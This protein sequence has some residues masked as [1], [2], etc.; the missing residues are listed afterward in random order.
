MIAPVIIELLAKYIKTT[1]AIIMQIRCM[2]HN[3]NVSSVIPERIIKFCLAV[4]EELH[5]NKFLSKFAPI[6]P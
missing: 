5:E 4:T 1:I 6:L 3:Y 2:L